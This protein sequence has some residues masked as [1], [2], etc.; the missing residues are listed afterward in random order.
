MMGTKLTLDTNLLE[1]T[2][3]AFI[4]F[5]STKQNNSDN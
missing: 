3:Q 1:Y 5:N 2:L 4:M